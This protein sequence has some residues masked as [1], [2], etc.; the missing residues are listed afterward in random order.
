M[1]R[2]LLRVY[3]TYLGFTLLKVNLPIEQLSGAYLGGCSHGH[4]L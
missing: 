2:I 1:G 4:C 3:F